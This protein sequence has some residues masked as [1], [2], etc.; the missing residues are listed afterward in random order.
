MTLA[1]SF[2]ALQ[3]AEFEEMLRLQRL[4]FREASKCEEAKAFLP[5]C[6]M[7][8]AALEAALIAMVHCFADEVAGCKTAPHVNGAVKP[9]L[10]W[11]LVELLRVAKTLGW[12]PA[13]LRLEE[14]WQQKRA[15]IGDHAEVLRIL[16]N[17]VHPAAYVAEHD[18]KRVISKHLAHAFQ[19]LDIASKHL[20]ARLNSSLR[21]HLG[22]AGCS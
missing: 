21:K 14:A 8:A 17:L 6:V 19:V 20:L 9:V 7:L 1:K 11:R 15:S 5:G 2:A 10:K 18:G 16:R 12:L 4:Y 22:M 3:D 13:G